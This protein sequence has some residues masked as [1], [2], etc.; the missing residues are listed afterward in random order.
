MAA[1]FWQRLCDRGYPQSFL[2]PF[3]AAVCD[4]SQQQYLQPAVRDPALVLH[5]LAVMTNCLYEQHSMWLA[6]VE[7]DVEQRYSHVNE[8]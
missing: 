2:Q 4:S 5:A 6:Q 7:N 3:F 1:V 8:L